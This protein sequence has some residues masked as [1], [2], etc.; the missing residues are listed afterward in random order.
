MRIIKSSLKGSKN[1]S[2][3]NFL[4]K[5]EEANI[6]Y[7]NDIEIGTINKIEDMLPI[8]RLDEYL[9]IEQLLESDKVDLKKVEGIAERVTNLTLLNAYQNLISL[10]LIDKEGNKLFKTN[11]DEFVNYIRDVINYGITRYNR[12]FGDYEGKF[13]LYANYYKEQ[14]SRIMLKNGTLQKGTYYENDIAYI[15]AGIKKDDEGKLNYKDKFINNSVF[16]WE[17]IADISESE[18]QHLRNSKKV[19]LFIRKM[20]N[21][22]SV[23]LPYTYFGLGELTNERISYTEE[24]GIHHPTLLY[25]IVLDKQVPEDYYIDFEI[26]EEVDE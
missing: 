19:H 18:K 26:P 4:K 8:V 9:I 7:F 22:D 11:D 17:S 13:K 25:D 12:E 10:D 16:Q 6:P 15:F 23:T 20:E 5:I 21:E 1:K 24:N 3:Y 14:A 2:Y